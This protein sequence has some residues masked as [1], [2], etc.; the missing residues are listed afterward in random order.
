MSSFRKPV[1]G[2]ALSTMVLL[3]ALWGTQQ[4]AIKL[5]AADVLPLVQVAL[6]SGIS[7]LLVGLLSWGRGERLSFRDGTWRPA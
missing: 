1:D 7:A 2:V 6:R 4:V 3:C 5:A